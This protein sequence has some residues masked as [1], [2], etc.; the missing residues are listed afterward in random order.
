[1]RLVTDA[2]IVREPVVH[3]GSGAATEIQLL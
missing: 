2:A 3:G 1:M